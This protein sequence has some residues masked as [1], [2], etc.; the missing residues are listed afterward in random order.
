VKVKVEKI[1]D[2]NFKVLASFAL[3]DL[4]KTIDKMAKEAG[5]NMKV[6]GFRKG[7]V[8]AHVVKK[9]HGEQLMQ[10]AEGEAIREALDEALKEVKA[11]KADMPVIV[12]HLVGEV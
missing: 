5:K 6:D 9:L 11:D 12:G 2:A 1:D 8:P 7:K 4:D 3:S 10:D